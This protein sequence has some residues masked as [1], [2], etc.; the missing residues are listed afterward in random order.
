MLQN[1]REVR[2]L[3]SNTLQD[4]PQGSELQ[5][6]QGSDLL[7]LL[8][9]ESGLLGMI[10]R[11]KS[12]IE[13]FPGVYPEVT[14]YSDLIRE[15]LQPISESFLVKVILEKR[16]ICKTKNVF[17]LLHL[18][19]FT[20]FQKSLNSHLCNAKNVHDILLRFYCDP[21]IIFQMSLL[22]IRYTKIIVIF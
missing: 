4:C 3:V 19:K 11:G 2:R 1:S 21:Y 22:S 13:A 17:M 14:H 5:A 12:Y 10:S 6:T 18:R 9:Q 20:I 15:E 8:K 16:K 7:G